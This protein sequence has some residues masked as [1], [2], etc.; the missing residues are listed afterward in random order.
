MY[1]NLHLKPTKDNLTNIDIL[2]LVKS[3]NIKI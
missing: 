1:R 2:K 3:T